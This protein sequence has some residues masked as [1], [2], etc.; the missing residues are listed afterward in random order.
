M[1]TYLI[2]IVKFVEQNAFSDYF[3]EM[4]ERNWNDLKIAP[5][6]LQCCV[7]IVH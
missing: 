5:L 1:T 3:V 4:M 7:L 2:K 6:M